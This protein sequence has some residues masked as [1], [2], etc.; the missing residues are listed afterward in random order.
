MPGVGAARAYSRDFWRPD[1][2]AG[3]TVAAYLVPQVMAYA[4]VAGLPPIVGVWAALGPLIV[5]AVAGSSPR[6][7]AGPESTTAILTAS[8]VG[9]IAAGDPARYAV[10][11][12]G[13]AVCTGAI[14]V[15]ARVLRLS[16]VAHFLSRPVLTGYMAGIAVLIAI[17]QLGTVTGVHVAHGSAATSVLSW[18]RQLPEADLTTVVLAAVL[19][20]G[21]LAG[22][23]WW[24][25]A[26]L[27]LLAVA[28][29]GAV[30][31][32]FHLRDHGVTVVGRIDGGLP[33][34][35]FPAVGGADWSRLLLPAVGV[36]VV[37]YTD[38]ILTARAFATR[39]GERIDA[40]QE[41]LALGLTNLAAGLTHG[42]SVSTSGSRT[43][44]G[45][46]TGSRTQLH[47]LVAA[48]AVVAVLLGAGPLLEQFPTAAL[49]ALVIWAATRLVDVTAFLRLARFRRSE[50]LLAAAATVGVLAFDILY[51]VLLAVALS[52]F[53]LLR[54]V[55]RPHAAVLGVA[56]DLPGMHDIDDNPHTQQI[57]G[58][59]VY[60]WDSPL[61]FANADAFTQHILAALDAA[62]PAAHALV[63]DAEAIVQTDLTALDALEQVRAECATRD[64]VFA[65]A[66]VKRELARDMERAG[67]L[68]RLDLGRKRLYPTLSAAVAG[69]NT[70]DTPNPAQGTALGGQ[71]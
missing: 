21:L 10:L 56:P 46:S 45:E 57:A 48:G 14:C 52:F 27:P 58:V 7:S 13:L 26:P 3:L 35:A 42:F 38:S 6:L 43:A 25:T 36:A 17:G 71:G 61:F 68:D 64:V 18:A 5:Y 23:R 41:L 62:R 44:I 22:S 2:V 28:A 60:R 20:V 12:A 66:Q 65:F 67:L 9:P 55:I 37:A 16:V 4:R 11:A 69:V 33:A 32:L 24:P 30:V 59:V 8:V 15:L 63:L 50:F 70:R 34:V 1:I 40:D 49:G 51:G 54:R 19:L 47:S 39:H 53:D 31:M 29:S